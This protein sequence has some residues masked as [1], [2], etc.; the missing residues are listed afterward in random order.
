[1]KRAIKLL[2]QDIK[3]NSNKE[4]KNEFE[5]YQNNVLTNEYILLETKLQQLE[6]ELEDL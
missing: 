3:Y 1:M 6:K 4:N 5:L 2:L